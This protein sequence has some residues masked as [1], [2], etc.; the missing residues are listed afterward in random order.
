ML[1]FFY[2]NPIKLITIYIIY[3]ILVEVKTDVGCA[4]VEIVVTG[5]ILVDVVVIMLGYEDNDNF[6]TIKHYHVH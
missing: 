4:L 3:T 2:K 1:I 6:P 5:V